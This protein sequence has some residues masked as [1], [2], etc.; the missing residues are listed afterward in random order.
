MFLLDKTSF[1]ATTLRGF[2]LA[3]SQ[4]PLW[5]PFVSPSAGRHGSCIGDGGKSKTTSGKQMKNIETTKPE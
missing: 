1:S 2:C 5:E 3:S 4:Q